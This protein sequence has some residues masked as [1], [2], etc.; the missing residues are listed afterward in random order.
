MN[1]SSQI[2]VWLVL[3]LAWLLGSTAALA[4][5]H[6]RALAAWWREPVLRR[7]VL[8]FES[9]DW[10][11]GEAAHASALQRLAE[12]LAAHRDRDG[13]HPVMTLGVVLALADTRR[14]R[15]AEV[16][17]Y[18]RVYLESCDEVA[19]AMRAGVERGVFAPQLHGLEH[20]WAPALL[21]RAWRDAEVK[22]WL[23]AEGL[24]RS[25]ALPAPLQSRWADAAQLPTRPLADIEI[26]AA[27]AEEVGRFRQVFGVPPAVAVPPTFV[28]TPVVE[29][30]WARHGVRCVVTPGRRYG[31]RDEKGRPLAEGDA[32]VNGAPGAG[33]VIYVV[34]DDYFEPARGHTAARALRALRLKTG[35]GRPTLLE[36]HRY[37]F[38]DD[39]A[40][41]ERAYAEIAALLDQVVAAYPDVAFLSTEALAE[42]LRARDPAW[43]EAG[44]RRR[45]GAWAA[46][47][48]THHALWRWSRLTGLGLLV[49]TLGV[50]GADR[51]RSGR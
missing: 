7:P 11:P 18:F 46:R 33:E 13:R 42:I 28:W 6:R 21:A 43:V 32:I 39:A 10:G 17:E 2:M 48:R 15:E 51:E 3:V 49:C 23:T 50:L 19:A 31:G 4:V 27:V 40:V 5:W 38:I 14:I 36:M 29:R 37:N 16:T 20:Y 35:L 30:A 44:H 47:V 25:E 45:L 24:P 9:D 41:A 8:I 1:G 34:R 26:D 22:A 12:L